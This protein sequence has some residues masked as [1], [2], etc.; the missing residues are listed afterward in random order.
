MSKLNIK[1]IIDFIIVLSKQNNIS[2]IENKDKLTFSLISTLV[3]HE[4][5][6]LILDK[7][8]S[9]EIIKLIISQNIILKEE[10][11]KI[12]KEN[13]ILIQKN[14]EEIKILENKIKDL[15]D[16]IFNI[17]NKNSINKM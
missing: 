8:Q 15:E 13:N 11:E 1:E 17:N 3:N 9:E 10:Y 4:N 12:K 5:V 7:K 2:I 6:D 14:S 16:K